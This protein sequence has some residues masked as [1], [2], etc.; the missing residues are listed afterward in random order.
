MTFVDS[1]NVNFRTDGINSASITPVV[2][3]IESFFYRNKKVS[4]IYTIEYLVWPFH[5]V[6]RGCNFEF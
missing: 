4:L 2:R 5:G 3:I 1:T 6:A